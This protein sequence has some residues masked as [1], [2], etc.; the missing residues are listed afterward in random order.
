MY[1]ALGNFIYCSP[2][3]PIVSLE[4]LAPRSGDDESTKTFD[5]PDPN[6]T[7]DDNLEAIEVTEALRAFVEGLPAELRDIIHRVYWEG[8]SQSSIARN[9]GVSGAAISKAIRKILNHGRVVLATYKNHPLTGMA[10][11]S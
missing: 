5:I 10:T 2:L 3:A 8:E 7:P 6:P 1:A 9:R 4:V 11:T